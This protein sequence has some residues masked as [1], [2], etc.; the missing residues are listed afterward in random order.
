[1]KIKFNAIHAAVFAVTVALSGVAAAAGTYNSKPL[2]NAGG[3]VVNFD[4]Q[5][6]NGTPFVGIPVLELTNTVNAQDSFLAFC[7]QPNVDLQQYTVYTAGKASVKNEVKALYETSYA[8][9]MK[10]TVTQKAFQLALWELVAD[11]GDIYAQQGGSQYFTSGA[12][13][14]ADAAFHMLEMAAE[15]TVLNNMYNYTSFTGI[16]ANGKASQELLGV[17]MAAAVPEA[18]TWAMLGLGLGLIGFMGRRK[19]GQDQK[20]A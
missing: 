11:D 18:S 10:D 9:A 5:N 20:F 3:L 12:D 1:M 16:G 19:S 2:D 15:H 14:S 6:F 8:S 4:G 7:V 13:E 17:S